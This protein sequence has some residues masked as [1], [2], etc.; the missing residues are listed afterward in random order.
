[1]TK[2]QRKPHNPDMG[3]QVL[4]KAD[5]PATESRQVDSD[6]D[7]IQINPM[8]RVPRHARKGL[9]V[10]NRNR[11]LA[12]PGAIQK[13]LD[14]YQAGDSVPAIAQRLGI[15]PAS[16]YMALLRNC[17]EEWQEYQAARA[18]MKLDNS[19]QEIDAATNGIM[20]GRAREK[21]GRDKW[22]LERTCRSI[23]GDR[24]EVTVNAENMADLLLAVSTKMLKE[25]QINSLPNRS[26]QKDEE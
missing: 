26:D 16:I 18:L 20:L 11:P 12:K 22:V 8:A 24:Q 5:D 17:P 15:Q 10:A 3:T 4:E 6:S 1:M 9:E 13:V 25:K 2:T 23:Y 7:T 14:D 19:D 21:L